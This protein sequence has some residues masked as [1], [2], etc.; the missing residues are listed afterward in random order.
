MKFLTNRHALVLSSLGVLG[1][2]V[3]TPVI[4]DVSYCPSNTFIKDSS[5]K[6]VCEGVAQ[7]D[8]S[9]NFAPNYSTSMPLTREN[10]LSIGP[11][12]MT[13]SRFV[14]E[15]ETAVNPVLIPVQSNPSE[16]STST[17]FATAANQMPTPVTSSTAIQ[18]DC[19]PHPGAA[20]VGIKHYKF[21][22]APQHEL[23][24]L[25]S[26]YRAGGGQNRYVHKDALA[27]LTQ[28]IDDAKQDGVTLTV[29]SAF[30][31]VAYQRG[32]KGGKPNAGASAWR[33]SAP[34]GY[35]EHH[36]GFAV[37]FNPINSSF[38]NTAAYRWLKANGAKYNWHQTFTAEY[39]RA[40]GVI[41]EA[42]HWK[43]QGSDTALSYT[44]NAKCLLGR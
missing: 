2:G 9:V 16:A 11:A 21:Q 4:A 8:N 22:E 19:T 31:S 29:G 27:S 26:R 17:A 5:G 20:K 12:G 1:M 37:D 6:L 33:S 15:T 18:S 23:V 32:L 24:E 28:M 13:N 41:E 30:R 25:P 34:A 7:N 44:A 36:T 40:S 14:S 10:N 39:S 43:Y 42:W 3:V 38:G 35:S